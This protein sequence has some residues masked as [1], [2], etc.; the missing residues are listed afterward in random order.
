MTIAPVN[1]LGDNG[2]SESDTQNQSLQVPRLDDDTIE[3]TTEQTVIFQENNNSTSC[4]RF[5]LVLISANNF[6]MY[7]VTKNI[8]YDYIVYD[9]KYITSICYL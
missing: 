3:H 9:W 6:S 4:V 7:L 8:V 5:S 1:Q 2:E